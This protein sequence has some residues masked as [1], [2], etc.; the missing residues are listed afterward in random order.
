MF[1]IQTTASDFMNKIFLA[2]LY[3]FLALESLSGKCRRESKK[4][5]EKKQTRSI[6]F[7]PGF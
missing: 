5:E 3:L 1:T 2:S 4:K 6:F 7:N